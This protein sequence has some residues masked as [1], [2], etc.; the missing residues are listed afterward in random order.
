MQLGFL[1]R[2]TIR[3]TAEREVGQIYVPAINWALFVAVVV[4]TLGF[5]SSTALA[6]AYGVAVT[7]TFVINT[8]LFLAVARALW[9]WPKWKLVLAGA[10]FLS[11]EVDVLRR[12]PH[13]DR[14][15]RLA[16]AHDRAAIFTVMMTWQRGREIVT[17]NRDD[18]GGRSGTSSRSCTARSS[19]RGCTESPSSSTPTPETTPFA[20]RANVEHNHV[21]HEN[22]V[23]IVSARTERVPHVPETVA[24]RNR[25]GHLYN[26]ATGDPL[27]PSAERFAA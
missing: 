24:R 19:C 16:A 26:A 18:E 13:E 3:H 7:G 10:V 21:L 6:T 5:G 12:E 9:R 2:L 14:P 4:V 23:I 25:A 22:V 20:L 15:R 11:V 8:I 1:P 27:G 17:A